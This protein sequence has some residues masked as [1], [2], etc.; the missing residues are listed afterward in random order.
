MKGLSPSAWNMYR[1]LFLFLIG[2]AVLVIILIFVI[3]GKGNSCLASPINYGLKQL[4][5]SYD[6]HSQAVV[7]IGKQGYASWIA[8]AD[9]N[10]PL[11]TTKNEVLDIQSINLSL[12]T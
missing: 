10:T 2:I 7:S 12:L 11:L 9:S 6:T 5:K 8:T 3:G 4:D 1:I